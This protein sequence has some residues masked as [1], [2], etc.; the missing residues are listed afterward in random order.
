MKMGSPQNITWRTILLVA[1]SFNLP[2]V[3][4]TQDSCKGRCQSQYDR[5]H[6]CHCDTQCLRHGE[7]CEDYRAL[8]TSET[9]CSGRCFEIHERGRNCQCDRNCMKFSDC[10]PDFVAN[11]ERENAS[12]KVMEGS[13]IMKD[14]S[15]ILDKGIAKTSFPV[16]AS[17]DSKILDSGKV[18]PI[19]EDRT[20]ESAMLLKTTTTSAVPEFGTMGS[21][22]LNKGMKM[23]T[24]TEDDSTNSKKNYK[25][26]TTIPKDGN[27]DSIS[28][29]KGRTTVSNSEAAS[30]ERR[31]SDTQTTTRAA[32][33]EVS[34]VPSILDRR[35]TTL[36]IPEDKN[37]DSKIPNKVATTVTESNSLNS[38]AM[39]VP[40]TTEDIPKSSKNLD[41][42]LAILSVSTDNTTHA[43][44]PQDASTVSK[45]LD[46]E[47]TPNSEEKIVP[48]GPRLSESVM[49]T[50]AL[51]STASTD[52]RILDKEVTSLSF[53]VNKSTISKFLHKTMTNSPF[54]TDKTR[55]SDILDNVMITSSIPKD[56]T[57][58]IKISEGLTTP[59]A[60]ADNLTDPKFLDKQITSVPE[61]GKT[62]SKTLD[63]RTKMYS[64]SEDYTT[65]ANILDKGTTT[66]FVPQDASS[67]DSKIVDK[68]M[69]RNPEPEEVPTG[70]RISGNVMKTSALPST[71]STDARILDKRMPSLAV[72]VTHPA[73]T[74]NMAPERELGSQ[75]TGNNQSYEDHL[76]D[77]NLCNKK[78]SDAMTTL[79]NGTTY[80]FRAHLFWTINQRG[81]KLGHPR[82]ITDV[83][84]I[85]S[86]IDTVFTRCNCNGNTYFFKGK[87][88]WRFQNGFMDSGY[89]RNI[90]VGFSGLSGKI[91][92]ALSVAAY[93]N[94]PET[95]YFFKT[96]GLYQKYVYQRPFTTCPQVRTQSYTYQ[97]VKRRY[98]RQTTMVTQK[99]RRRQKLAEISV[100]MSIRKNWYGLPVRV[101][102]AISLPNPRIAEKYEY[103]VLSHDKSYKIDPVNQ[104]AT[105]MKR[106]V[107]KDLYTCN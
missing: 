9:S 80:I 22:T 50:S 17:I 86:P 15:K 74:N 39:T 60:S 56:G 10:C 21:K 59:F 4:S 57:R 26:M 64:A 35:I 16:D 34:S 79:Q 33:E 75:T 55:D 67:T 88:Y 97:M 84:G 68:G 65:H 41:N 46:R 76:N 28:L 73:E 27:T 37:N 13:A 71:A 8:C 98:R 54:P 87:E 92:A 107:T 48:T 24:V 72:R 23:T 63:N 51:P 7:C 1:F 53:V 82:R 14:D 43:N 12:A 32:P 18:T 101:T 66:V 25:E 95:V 104:K 105:H 62:H 2:N 30:K 106:S 3:I 91:T 40:S 31:I 29:D 47:I 20:T 99:T 83:W 5:S 93:R 89:P 81:Q 102:S 45:N 103:Y 94:R 38:N 78:P 11:C 36:S 58:D 85:P 77:P 100:E 52:A 42:R 19:S 90:A 96:G 61:D 44:I 69:T 70:P 49:T 6:R